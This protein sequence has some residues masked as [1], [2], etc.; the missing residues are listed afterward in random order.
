MR[1]NVGI[2]PKYLLDQHLLAE[3]RE[4][5]M[6]V[7]SLRVNGWDIKSD[8]PQTF[9]LGKGHINFFK[10]RLR[11]LC[12]RHDEVVKECYARDFNCVSLCM[13]PVFYPVDYCKGWKP[14]IDDSMVIRKRVVEKI[15]ARYEKNPKFWRHYRC[16]LSK[17]ELDEATKRVLEGDLF[18]V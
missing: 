16:V 13:N 4:L 15:W 9:G 5:P 14:T 8:I 1:C 3:Y 7:G 6:V 10:I 2:N 11:Y 18:Y 12:R 17:S